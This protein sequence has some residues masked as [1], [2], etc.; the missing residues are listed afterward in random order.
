MQVLNSN[1]NAHT[2]WGHDHIKLDILFRSLIQARL[3]ST[4]TENFQNIGKRLRP[5]LIINSDYIMDF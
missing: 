2:R 1:K 3:H 5:G 4:D